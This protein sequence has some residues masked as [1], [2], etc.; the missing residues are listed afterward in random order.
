MRY[1]WIPVYAVVL[2]ACA[3]HPENAATPCPEAR[4]QVCTLEYNPSCGQ[5]SDGELRNY[6]SRC[7]ACADDQV[8]AVTVGECAE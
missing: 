6:S 2:T 7:N 4:P 3:G 5:R 1:A 8:V